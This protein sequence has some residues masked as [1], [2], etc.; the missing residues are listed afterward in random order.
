MVIDWVF[1]NILLNLFLISHMD[2]VRAISF[3]PFKFGLV[4]GGEDHVVKIWN[5]T[6]KNNR[7]NGQSGAGWLD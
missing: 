2:G 7:Y 4:S 5:L 6:T 3:H 1:E